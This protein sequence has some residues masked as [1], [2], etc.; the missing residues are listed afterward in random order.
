MDRFR[1]FKLDGDRL[2][3]RRRRDEPTGK[4]CALPLVAKR[5][6]AYSRSR[7]DRNR[8]RLAVCIVAFR[9]V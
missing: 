7:T 6:I 2:S 1:Y 5:A 3:L 4:S 9:H 8:R